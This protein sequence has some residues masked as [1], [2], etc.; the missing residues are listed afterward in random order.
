MKKDKKE[1][2]A[3]AQASSVGDIKNIIEGPAAVYQK[4]LNEGY[5]IRDGKL[6]SGEYEVKNKTITLSSQDGIKKQGKLLTHIL[7]NVR[8]DDL[9]LGTNSKERKQFLKYYNN[10]IKR[11][12]RRYCALA[13]VGS[14]VA[15]ALQALTIKTTITEDGSL[16]EWIDGLDPFMLTGAIALVTFICL[17]ILENK[18]RPQFNPEAQQAQGAEDQNVKEM[19]NLLPLDWAKIRQTREQAQ[20]VLKILKADK[21]TSFETKDILEEAMT[22][23]EALGKDN[24]K[25]EEQIQ[26]L[27]S[28]KNSALQTEIDALYKLRAERREKM[29]TLSSEVNNLLVNLTQLEIH[30]DEVAVLRLNTDTNYIKDAYTSLLKV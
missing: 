15:G 16:K 28:L 21:F 12:R 1:L 5:L 23:M 22:E 13:A 9:F 14:L 2:K 29:L 4:L 10:R 20:D 3:L 30:D 25:E 11:A 26:H 17:T 24:F 19:Q 27:K 8:A 7:A 18:D 6:Q